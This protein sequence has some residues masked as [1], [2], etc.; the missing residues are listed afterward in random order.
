MN[1][2]ERV[3]T[4][5]R[6]ITALPTLPDVAV[7]LLE[8]G[9]KPTTSAGD[10]ARLVERDM[11]LA[12]R[13]LRLVNSSFFGVRREVTSIQHAVMILGV[14]NLRSIVLSGAVS[15]LFDRKGAV[16]SFNR[17][18]FWK[19]SV[20]VAATSRIIAQKVKLVDAEI[21]FTAGLIHDMGKVVV[22]RYLHPEFVRVV[23]L[24]DDPEM[25]MRNAENTVL[26]V[27]HAEIGHH[28]A[29]Y[30]NLPEIL[31]EAV[32]YHHR[33]LEAPE[34][35]SV[36]AIVG[37]ADALVRHLGIGQGGGANW[38]VQEATLK[39]CDLTT[40][41]YAELETRLADELPEQV[42]G[43]ASQE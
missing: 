32:G 30:W 36:A 19:H 6:N 25:T 21:A 15:D 5:L 35:R 8:L 22:D 10:L 43:Y 18:E 13:V 12:T 4:V 2:R 38:P 26:G 37:T 28:L 23:E 41:S 42:N 24:L 39:L 29:V 7:K 16:G 20:A 31:L 34:Y 40:E 1:E 11:S 17:E 9:E 3:A 33:P 14:S 27:N